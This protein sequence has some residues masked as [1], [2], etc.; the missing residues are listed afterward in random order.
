M[1]EVFDIVYMLACG[2][3][4]MC[5]IVNVWYLKSSDIPDFSRLNVEETFTIVC[6]IV[7]FAS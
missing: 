3:C 2:N 6:R 5:D 1:F 7:Y 4:G